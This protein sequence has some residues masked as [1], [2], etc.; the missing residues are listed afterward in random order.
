MSNTTSP[1][2]AP[3][4]AL[5]WV[6]Y[7]TAPSDWRGKYIATHERDIPYE[8]AEGAVVIGRVADSNAAVRELYRL[9][10]AARESAT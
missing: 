4:S 8:T 5:K 1:A 3:S 7:R 10:D 9:S 2:T 6:I